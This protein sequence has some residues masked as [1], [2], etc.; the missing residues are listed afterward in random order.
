VQGM[1]SNKGL[2]LNP[3]EEQQ[4]ADQLRFAV[5]DAIC[6]S[7]NRRHLYEEALIAITLEE[8]LKRYCQRIPNSNFWGGE[9]ELLVSSYHLHC[10]TVR[11]KLTL[12]GQSSLLH[13]YT[14]DCVVTLAAFIHFI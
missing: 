1:A 4:E 5:M 11:T 3:T 14:C 7:D 8:S 10:I 6:R 12:G 2:G 13:L 9:S